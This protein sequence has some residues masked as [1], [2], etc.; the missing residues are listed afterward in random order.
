[1]RWAKAQEVVPVIKA[2]RERAGQIANAE[3]ER[4]L[5]GLRDVDP[6]TKKSIQ[7][8]S[9]AIVN[10]LLHPVLTQLKEAGAQGDPQAHVAALTELFELELEAPREAAAPTDEASNVVPLTRSAGGSER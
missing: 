10:K 6:K 3:A 9:K 1:M 5:S 7:A 8:M 4:T 2:L